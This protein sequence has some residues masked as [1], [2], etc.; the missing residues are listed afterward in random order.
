MI[1]DRLKQIKVLLLD[2]DGVLTDG[3]II[4]DDNGMETKVF[5]VRDGL[6]IRLLMKAGIQV[7]VVTGRSS[8]ALNH[9]CK[10]LG[11]DHIFDGLD[12]KGVVL[13]VVFKRTGVP[14]EEIAFVGDDLPDLVLMKKVGLSIAV[15]NAH[16]TVVKNA[17]A[18]TKCEGGAGAVREICEAILKARGIWDSIIKGFL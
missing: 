12:D 8:K 5:N 2:V 7:G 16:E 11:I 3:G 14:P 15:K 1:S 6:G 4:Y 18:V 17:D 13:D 9:R 10:N